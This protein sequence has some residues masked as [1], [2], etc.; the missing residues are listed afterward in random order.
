MLDRYVMTFSHD[1]GLDDQ[2]RSFVH[3]FADGGPDFLQTH[4]PDQFV[5][6]TPTGASTVQRK[7]FIEAAQQRAAMVTG[8]G[9]PAPMLSSAE[10]VALGD[11][12]CLVTATL[13]MSVPGRHELILTEDFLIDR[14]G[15]NWRCLAYLLRQDLPGL[16]AAP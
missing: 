7:R 4:L 10:C 8:Q 6:G 16:L 1:P 15:E 3:D 11:A 9:L 14:A 12:Y 13:T 2:A 5:V